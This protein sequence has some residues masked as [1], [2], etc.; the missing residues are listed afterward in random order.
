MSRIRLGDILIEQGL[1]EEKHLLFALQVQKTTREKLGQILTRI[2]LINEYDLAT[3][4]ARQ[5]NLEFIDLNNEEP[6]TELLKKF[7]R[8]TCLTHK[9]FP[10]RYQN[11]KVLLATSDLPGPQLEQICL[12]FTGKKPEYVVAEETKIVTSIYN[13]F[14][15]LENPVGL[16]ANGQA[17]S[18]WLN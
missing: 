5:L 12:R 18:R 15:F 16:D 11:N 4:L 7:N 2:G 8:H 13:Y 1:I 17:R 10:L 14:Y 3:I 9:I 6:D